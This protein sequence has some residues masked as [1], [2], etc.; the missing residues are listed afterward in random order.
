MFVSRVTLRVSVTKK[1][2][3]LRGDCSFALLL[4]C[5]V[6]VPRHNFIRA[7]GFVSVYVVCA[8]PLREQWEST[9][10]NMNR[11]KATCPDKVA[12]RNNNKAKVAVQKEQSPLRMVS[13]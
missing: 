12:P 7:C 13:F 1:L 10:N 6:V 9:H 2:T 4:V 11:D 5:L 8:V 3:I